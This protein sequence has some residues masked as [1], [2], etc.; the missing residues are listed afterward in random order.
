MSE[1]MHSIDPDHLQMLTSNR[2]S[3]IA[4]DHL[5][6]RKELLQY[7]DIDCLQTLVLTLSIFPRLACE[8]ESCQS[9]VQF[10]QVNQ[11]VD[12]EVIISHSLAR[13]D[14]YESISG[15][16]DWHVQVC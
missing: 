4:T 14:F 12:I 16:G 7:Q 10:G 15:S 6:M 3:G 2:Q 5:P 13:S 9:C 1:L 8:S 11:D